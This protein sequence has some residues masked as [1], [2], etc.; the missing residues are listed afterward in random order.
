[1]NRTG[2]AIVQGQ[3]WSCAAHDWVELQ[4]PTALPLWE[5]ILDAAAV[6][7]G[8]HVLD[9]GCGAG[10]VSLLAVGRGAYVNGLDAGE[11]LL[12][13]A[14]WRVP[15]GDF[16]LG[17]LEMLPYADGTFEAILVAD[18]LPY[19]PNLRSSI[20]QAPLVTPEREQRW[21]GEDAV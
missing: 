7:S 9:A 12:T 19:V 13:I 11:A 2:S 18:V 1:M 10:G 15:D 3:L 6:R 21:K 16:H 8:T 4:E 20:I 17:D 14:R 5:A